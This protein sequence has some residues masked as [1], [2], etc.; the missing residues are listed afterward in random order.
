[1]LE[2]LF[3]SKTRIKILDYLLF[4]K[5]ETYLREIAKDLKLY[6]SAVKREIDNLLGL[7]LIKKQKNKII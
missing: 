7:G 2:K 3:T 6:P 5:K 1:M 4:H